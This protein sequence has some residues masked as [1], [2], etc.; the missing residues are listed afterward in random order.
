MD[1][2]AAVYASIRTTLLTFLAIAAAVAIGFG[3]FLSSM[4]ATPLRRMVEV[5]GE[6][7]EGR[8]DQRI[9]Y[10]A[11]DETGQLSE[12]FRKMIAGFAAPVKESA[13]VLGRVAERDLTAR[14]EGE[15]AKATSHGH[16]GICERRRRKLGAALTGSPTMLSVQVSST[17]QQLSCRLRRTTGERRARNRRRAWK[18]DFVFTGRNLRYGQ[19]KCRERAPGASTGRDVT[20]SRR[21]GRRRG[22]RSGACHGRNQLV[23]Q[24][25][26]RHHHDDR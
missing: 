22:P 13:A 16:K 18:R 4:L 1:Q 14:M 19:A 25:D 5:A 21:K 15:C 8:L 9:D 2:S 10:R 17:S 6:L 24:A 20:R 11:S 23:V 3:L 26:R 7:A 12:A